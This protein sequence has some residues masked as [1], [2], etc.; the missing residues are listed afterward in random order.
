MNRAD[1]PLPFAITTELLQSIIDVLPIGI[2]I[3]DAHGQ[4]LINNPVART[5][6]AGERW[7]KPS[8][9]GEYKAWWTA[10]GERIEAHD[11]GLARAIAH[12]ETS[13]NEMVD[14]ECFDGSR[15]TILNSA[16]PLR[17][18]DGNL[19]AGIAT[20]Q[21]ITA[22]K[23]TQDEL[24]CARSE[25]E[26]LAAELIEVRERE[27][28]DLSRELHDGIGQGLTALK[29]MIES[30]RRSGSDE[31]STTLDDALA[32]VDTLVTDTREMARWLRP[33]QL[34]DLGLAAALRWHLDRTVRAC[35]LLCQFTEDLGD[36]RPPP[37]I[38]QGAFR[39]AQEA[40][41]N[42]IQH[43]QARTVIVRLRRVPT[44]LELSIADD[45]SGFDPRR[46]RHPDGRHHLGL[47][48]MRERVLMLGGEL[49]IDSTPGRGTQIVAVFPVDAPAGDKK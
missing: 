17:D 16:I 23:H 6:W 39:I 25:L 20:N 11:W 14:I 48:G 47:I 45:G 21:D 40:I 3:A 8:E 10:T 22:L 35:G 41:A 24:M 26:A 7:L 49:R 1:R 32:L 34:D 38:E 46:T 15:K 18:M 44:R 33:A 37:A 42:I 31:N 13:I 36:K 2:W 27:R 30:V 9:F 12:G 43:A 4:L 19:I 5:I 29:F 28:Q